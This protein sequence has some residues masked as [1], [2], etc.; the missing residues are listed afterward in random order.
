MQLEVQQ[1]GPEDLGTEGRSGALEPDGVGL[2]RTLKAVVE[3]S[4]QTYS[5]GRGVL[6]QRDQCVQ[7][8]ELWFGGWMMYQS[9]RGVAWNHPGGCVQEAGGHSESLPPAL[10]GSLT[11]S[12]LGMSD[13]S[14]RRG[15]SL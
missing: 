12:L 15:S 5:E 6:E 14:E 9:R 8:T 10:R 11:V 2:G 3:F 7:R 1:G 13:S 4:R